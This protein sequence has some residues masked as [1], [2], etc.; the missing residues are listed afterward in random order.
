MC[1]SSGYSLHSTIDLGE[2]YG[3]AF[4]AIEVTLPSLPVKSVE[5]MAHFAAWKSDGDELHC[6]QDNTAIDFPVGVK[7]EAALL[8]DR[9]KQLPLMMG[10]PNPPVLKA[11]ASYPGQRYAPV[12]RLDAGS[13]HGRPYTL[14]IEPRDGAGLGWHQFELPD[15]KI[16]TLSIERR[17]CSGGAWRIC[18]TLPAG[19]FR[20]E[21]QGDHYLLTALNLDEAL[22]EFNYDRK[23]SYPFNGW[24]CVSE[25]TIRS[26]NP[27]AGDQ[28]WGRFKFDSLFMTA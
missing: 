5:D 14:R 18:R 8:S 27:H 1:S 17:P 2:T 12:V 4:F 21:K 23:L 10:H 22:T 15:G 25:E 11:I 20:L 28:Q 3:R 6:V 19:S 7:F 9:G 13:Y 26:F 24:W 16:L